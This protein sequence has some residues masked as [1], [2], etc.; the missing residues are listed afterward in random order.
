MYHGTYKHAGQKK[1]P[2]RKYGD[3]VHLPLNEK[4]DRIP[5][6]DLSNSKTREDSSPASSHDIAESFHAECKNSSSRSVI[7]EKVSNPNLVSGKCTQVSSANVITAGNVNVTS[8]AQSPLV[9]SNVMT[10]LNSLLSTI[11]PQ[12]PLTSLLN[13]RTAPRT[14]YPPKPATVR[15]DKPFFLTVLKSY[16]SRFR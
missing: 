10:S 15:S 2:R 13:S 4:T 12:L 3:A 1:P 5:L 14:T 16:V 11:Y 7:S 8:L 6:T 9:L